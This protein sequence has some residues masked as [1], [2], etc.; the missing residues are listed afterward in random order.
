MILFQIQIENRFI[1]EPERHP[2]RAVHPDRPLTTPITGKFMCPVVGRQ[3]RNVGNLF[4]YR[5]TQLN[6]A[7]QCLRDTSG[8][9]CTHQIQESTVPN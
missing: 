7:C 4:K 1:P 2:P 3:L 8:A 9:T 6:A 5:E